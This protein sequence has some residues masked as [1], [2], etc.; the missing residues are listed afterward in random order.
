LF[1]FFPKFLCFL[2]SFPF[3]FPPMSLQS[4]IQLFK[5]G[6]M[7]EKEKTCL[8]ISVLLHLL[9]QNVF[10]LFCI[11]IVFLLFCYFENVDLTS[12]VLRLISNP[13]SDDL[14]CY[15]LG[16]FVW[17]FVN[18]GIVVLLL[19]KQCNLPP[20]PD[21]LIFWRCHYYIPILM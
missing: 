9:F 4:M 5:S 3:H 13:I 2:C 14:H 12:Q 21:V 6:R 8:F 16:G 17:D 18:G 7:K 20:N 10:L 19:S 15:I 1:I 11:F